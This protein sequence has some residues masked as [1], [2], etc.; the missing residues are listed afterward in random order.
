MDVITYPYVPVLP[1]FI[2]KRDTLFIFSDLPNSTEA[3]EEV[4]QQKTGEP[5]TQLSYYL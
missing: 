2:S 1:T 3:H 4:C 5:Y